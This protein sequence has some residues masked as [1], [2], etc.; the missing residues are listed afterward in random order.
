MMRNLLDR[1]LHSQ[2]TGA[3]VLLAATTLAILWANSPWADAYFSIS[4]LKLGIYVDDEPY[5][6]SLDH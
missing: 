4:E 3:I 6:L 1:F 2:T 5:L